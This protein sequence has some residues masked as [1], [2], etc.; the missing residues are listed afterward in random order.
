M[1]GE[2]RLAIF[3]AI[4]NM[5]ADSWGGREAVSWLQSG[6]G[7]HAQRT[8]ARCRYDME[9]AKQLARDMIDGRHA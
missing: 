5:T 9:H 2:E 6:G 4:R 1:S 7:L 3:H 8:V